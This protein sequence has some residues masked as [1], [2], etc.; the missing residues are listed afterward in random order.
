MVQN[1][2]FKNVTSNF[3][4][5][6]SDDFRNIK[7]NP[8]LLIAADKSNNLDELI[9]DE[10]NKLLTE[11]IS[12][13]HKKSN[14]S[15]MRT[16]NAE[17]KVIAQVLKIDQRIEQ[18]N[19]KQSFITLKDHKENFKNNPKCRLINPAK[20]EIGIVSKEYTDSINKTIR[21]KINVNQW[22]NTAVVTWFQNIENKD[23]SFFV[24][25]YIV[26]FFPSLSKDFLINAINFAKSI[27]PFDDKIIK[28]ILLASK[29]LQFR[30][31]KSGL[32]KTILILM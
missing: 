7:K 20:S 11:N 18:Y 21:E 2:E 30:K 4:A 1:I 15:I 26:H 29:S 10:Y 6:L 13:T 14:L 27:T 25:F 28:T 12:K 32:K 3:Q 5:R 22:R 9:I 16:I 8:K 19:E 24:K 23:I 17:A 31:N